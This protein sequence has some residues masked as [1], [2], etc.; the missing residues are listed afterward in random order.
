MGKT[1]NQTRGDGE[2]AIIYITKEELQAMEV[3]LQKKLGDFARMARFSTWW[4]MM[5]HLHML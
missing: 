1:T 3:E 2:S 4:K 5:N